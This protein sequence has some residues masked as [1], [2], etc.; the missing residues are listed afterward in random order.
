MDFSFFLLSSRAVLG[1]SSF[2]FCLFSL[3]SNADDRTMK[4]V[5][6]FHIQRGIVAYTHANEL[7]TLA[8]HDDDLTFVWCFRHL[9]SFLLHLFLSFWLVGT[10]LRAHWV[11]EIGRG[12]FISNFNPMWALRRFHLYYVWYKRRSFGTRMLDDFFSNSNSN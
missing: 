10:Y 9:F 8:I 6:K 12:I 7:R 2:M 5:H 11:R 3:L 4:V 1:F